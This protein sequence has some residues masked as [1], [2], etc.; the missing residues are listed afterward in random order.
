[1]AELEA[2]LASVKQLRG[3]LPICSYCKQVRGDH[4][5]WEQ[6]EQYLVEHSDLRFS[7]G[8]CPDCYDKVAGE[9]LARS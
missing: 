2:A 6:V 3:L 1:V 5:Y 7:H 8:I 9:F 4:D